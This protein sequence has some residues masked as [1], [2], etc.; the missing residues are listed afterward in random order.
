MWPQI[1]GA[2]PGLTRADLFAVSSEDAPEVGQ[3]SYD[4]SDPE[5]PQ[6][7]TVAVDGS[8]VVSACDDPVVVI[9]EHTALGVTLSKEIENPV[10]LLVVIDRALK[11]FAERKFLVLD[12]PGEEEIL[13]RAF[14]SK[15]EM[16][17]DAT[18]IGQ[19]EL[20]QI[21]WLPSM[22]PTKTGFMEADE[23]F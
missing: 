11:D 9:A 23:Y 2:Y 12:I 21:P 10:D 7:G 18:I 14:A 22:A 1:A 16:P 8:F 5:G 6:M 19:V 13:I 15:A 17:A 4:F 3:W 20:V